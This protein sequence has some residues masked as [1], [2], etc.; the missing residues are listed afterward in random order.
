M[1]P[2]A[3]HLR[4]GDMRS[5]WFT[6]ALIGAAVLVF[7]GVLALTAYRNFFY[8][9][10]SF[11][12]SR[13]TWD[14]STFMLPHNGHWST[15]PIFVWKLLF[16]V[17]GLRSHVPFE[18]ALLLT[19]VAAVL[20]LFAL[21]RRRSGDLPAFAAA[22]TLLVLG[23]GAD[24]IVWAFQIA[25]AGSVAFGLFA[26]L[27]LDGNPPFPSRLPA[28]SA[29]LLGSLMCS[30][31]GI[32]FLVAVGVQLALDGKRRRFLLALVLPIAAFAGWF[33]AFDT[34]RVRGSPGVS[35]ALLNG[36]EGSGY[37]DRLAAFVGTGLQASAAGLFGLTGTA[38]LVF[39]VLSAV[40][41]WHWYGQ[42]GITSWELGLLVGLVGWFTLV[43]LGRVQFGSTAATLPRYLYVGIVF[44]LPL[45]AHAARDLPWRGLWR[46]TLGVAF[47]VALLGNCVQ[48]RDQAISQTDF[49][50]FENAELQTVDVFRNAPDL[51]P[52]SYVDE[53]M[54]PALQAGD[55][56]DATEQL[57]DPVPPATIDTLQ[58]LPSEA[59]NRVMLNLFGGAFT[60]NVDHSR[61]IQGLAC[62]SVDSSA[63]ATIGLQVADGQAIML[64]ANGFG[65]VD[66]WL[67]FSGRPPNLPWTR[68]PLSASTPIWITLPSTGVPVLWQ[69]Q[70]NTPSVGQ[71]EVCGTERLQVLKSN[72]IYRSQGASFTL[73]PGWSSVPDDA[74]SVG[75]C[76]KVIKGT[77]PPNGT[78][79]DEFVPVPRT[80]DIWYRVRV[81]TAVSGPSEITL[82]LT[83]VTASKYMA[84]AT[85]SADQ[86]NTTYSWLRIA[87]NVIPTSGHS[88]RFQANVSATLTTD[89]YIDAAVMVPSGSPVPR[90]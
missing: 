5:R 28:V 8:D 26:M 3:V 43:G 71:I 30:S 15:I 58:R 33:F 27:L 50:R 73:G 22:L 51:A 85:F 17:V 13:R 10:W 25:W 54:M 74:A 78:Y 83:D 34:G 80:Y 42:G 63:G 4:V 48:L 70:I 64:K 84:A 38:P 40:L 24:D 67:W 62:H 41:V 81:S 89:W 75:N 90:P 16:V 82:T 88:M 14:W 86:A 32:A 53:S 31:V 61:T 35:G 77:R 72:N 6:R 39:V 19:H 18:A 65:E 76:A 1:T 52:H 59:V 23:S 44:L 45:V 66:L 60:A 57:G 68:F 29:A 12:V 11:A 37:I 9:E 36:A 79:G 69:L 47:A 46:P 56:L 20:L 87:T 2:A 49:M 55:Y 7:G 21:I